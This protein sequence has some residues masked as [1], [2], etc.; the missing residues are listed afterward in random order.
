[1]SGIFEFQIVAFV[2]LRFFPLHLHRKSSL[3]EDHVQIYEDPVIVQ[4]VVEVFSHCV[5]EFLKDL[6]DLCHLHELQFS[7]AVIGLHDGLWLNEKRRS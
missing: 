3:G 1:M 6:L 4:Q 5:A 7:Q 2:D